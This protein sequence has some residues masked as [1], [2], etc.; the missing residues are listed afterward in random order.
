MINDY[1]V[2]TKKD[3]TKEQWDYMRTAGFFSMKIPKEWGGKGFSTA[4]VSAVLVKVSE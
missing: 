4:C 1:E 2:T 3:F